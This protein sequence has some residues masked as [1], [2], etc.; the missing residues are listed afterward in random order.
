MSHP[1]DNWQ[2]PAFSDYRVG[3]DHDHERGEGGLR[4]VLD[5]EP[6]PDKWKQCHGQGRARRMFKQNPVRIKPSPAQRSRSRARLTRRVCNDL[7]ACLSPHPLAENRLATKMH[8]AVPTVI[9]A[10]LVAAK[11]KTLSGAARASV[12]KATR[13]YTVIEKRLRDSEYLAG[14]Y[15]IADMAVYPWIRPY[16]W[17]G[18]ELSDY[19]AI[20]RWYQRIHDRPAVERGVA[21]LKD[22][23]DRNRAEPTG[24]NWNILFG[25]RTPATEE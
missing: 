19:P 22:R 3:N 14:S 18:Q 6:P 9:S 24:D 13:L 12:M 5:F 15:S 25:G 8:E 2:L 10:T 1:F 16:R 21:V 4:E 11:C 17:Q 7:R 23:L 20:Q